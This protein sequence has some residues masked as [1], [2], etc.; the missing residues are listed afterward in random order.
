MTIAELTCCRN[1]LRKPALL[2]CIG[3][4]VYFA[5]RSCCQC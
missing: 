1:V 5:A 2:R 3:Q 4:P